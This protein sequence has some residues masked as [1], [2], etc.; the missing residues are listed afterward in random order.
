MGDSSRN[1]VP[2]GP[3]SYMRLERV[4]I[5]ADTGSWYDNRIERAGSENGADIH[6]TRPLDV[7]ILTLAAPLQLFMETRPAI[8]LTGMLLPALMSLMLVF[9]C[10]WALLPLMHS[11][12]LLLIA[13]LV[14]VQPAIQ[15][16]L[17][18]GKIDHHAVLAVIMA[19]ILGCLIRANNSENKVRYAAIAGSLSGLGIWISLEF[20]IVYVPLTIGLGLCWIF[21]GSPWRQIN[22]SFALAVLCVCSV[23][24]LVDTP[25]EEWLVDRYDRL[26][27]AQVF[28]VSCPAV[29]WI[30]FARISDRSK[31]ILARLSCATIFAAICF[32]LILF[33]FPDLFVGPL[34]E[35]DP[36]INPIWHDK[37]VEMMPIITNA[38]LV[39]LYC[40]LPASCLIYGC[41]VLTGRMQA[42]QPRNWV[43]LIVLLLCTCAL[44]LA[45]IRASLYLSVAAVVAA[46]PLIEQLIYFVNKRFSGWRKG[47][48]GLTIRASFIIGPF[49]LAFLVGSITKGLDAKE[50]KASTDDQSVQCNIFDLVDFLSKDSFVKGRK[51]LRFANHIDL[52]PELIYRTQHH[53]LAVPYHRNGNAIFDTY[54]MLSAPDFAK[55]EILLKKYSI[56]Y[57][58]ICPNASE[59]SY[60]H[61]ETESPTVYDQI[62][63]GDL[64][65][66][67]Q[68]VSVPKPWQM[69]EYKVIQQ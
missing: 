5:L 26:T 39:V 66:A 43:W 51:E 7:F 24:F 27:I 9:I 32:T 18:V 41:L 56:D 37:V 68:S 29:F 65:D 4:N 49:C 67:L 53:F 8:E 60:Y 23:G 2:H 20:L 62:L 42:R 46:G 19:G 34:A 25:I 69:F 61:E 14:A 40:L 1:F 12:N 45:H 50:A 57:I 33:V 35:A 52:G 44:S 63:S 55:S 10:I 17:G 58:L 36:R 28:L 22:K 38:K 16:Y 48:T 64:P 11:P 21:W 30:F 3:D 31:R 47:L 13:I 6:W 15:S 54:A 59:Q